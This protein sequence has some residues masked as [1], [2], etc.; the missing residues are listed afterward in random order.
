M[1]RPFSLLIIAVYLSILATESF[2]TQ[3]VRTIYG[4]T[5]A[6][7]FYTKQSAVF[8]IQLG[9]FSKQSNAITL[10]NR[11]RLKTKLP[12]HVEQKNGYYAVMVGPLKTAQVEGL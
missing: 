9:S 4:M 8:G 12:V 7:H 1:K 2:A 6:Q 11:I 5:S 10:G 3:R